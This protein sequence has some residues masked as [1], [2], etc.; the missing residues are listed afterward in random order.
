MPRKAARANQSTPTK[1]TPGT[2]ITIPLNDDHSEKARRAAKRQTLQEAQ[3]NKIIAA[4]TPRKAATTQPEGSPVVVTPGRGGVNI[5]DAQTP[6]KKVPI[7]ANFEEWMKMATDNKINAANSWNFALIDY[8]HD[9]SLLK[10][11]N[12]VNFQKASCTLD[13]CVKIYT[14]RVDSVATETGKLLSG[15]A[16]N[17]GKKKGDQEEGG[18][19]GEDGDD[20]DEEGGKRKARKRATRSE[21]TLAKDISQLQLKKFDLEF[22]VDPLFKKAAADFD[23]GGAKGLLLNVLSIDEH[24][25]I[26]F[27]SSDD[28]KDSTNNAEP[29]DLVNVDGDEEDEPEEA[30]EAE[31]DDGVDHM[32]AEDTNVTSTEDNPTGEKKKKEG[33]S[34][35]PLDLNALASKFFPDLANIE[36]L[37]IC[38]SL[39]NF[40]LGDP[41]ASLD[42]P[43]LKALTEKEEEEQAA[44]GNDFD[45]GFDDDDD[46]GGGFDVAVPGGADATALYGQGGEAWASET[47]GGALVTP[48]KGSGQ[49]QDID[50]DG[51][52]EFNMNDDDY[53][54]K[55]GASR[56]NE[57]ED[58]L[59]YFDEALKKNW[60]GPEHWR[61][62]RIKEGNAREAAVRPR[63]E[64]TPFTIDFVTPDENLDDTDK[65]FATSNAS[66]SL[67]KTQI[68]NKTRNLLP[69]DKHFNSRQLLRL[70]LKPKAMLRSKKMIKGQMQV[71][72]SGG[73]QDEMVMDEQFWAQN[74]IAVTST[75]E[76]QQGDYDA[77]FFHDEPMGGLNDDDE[78]FADAREMF[79]P[80]ADG[81]GAAPA[82]DE[83]G[84]PVIPLL[85]SIKPEV[86]Y[87]A[88]LVTSSRRVRPEYVQYARVA[89]KV[90]V[91]KLKETMWRGMEFESIDLPPQTPGK[92]QLPQPAPEPKTPPP[93]EFPRTFT[94]LMN[95]LKGYYPKQ[96]MNDISTSYC[97]IS[98]LHLANEKGLQIAGDGTLKE[99]YIVR[100]PDAEVGGEY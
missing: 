2:T 1:T 100:D 70:F 74:E 90:D 61:I 8:F 77:N 69:D 94:T 92:A 26:V 62:R 23:E 85:D 96:A 60:A 98:L 87:G 59:A 22:A 55:L 35:V 84:N 48:G 33:A 6:Q 81:A 10:E 52:G 27:D 30:Q 99:L 64:K 17:S 24:G 93:P 32:D 63:K 29:A 54:V 71:R 53:I 56:E 9:M 78:D 41:N 49:I 47:M 5:V 51:D 12:S 82:V 19:E 72:G 34:N 91:R 58:I 89:K 66:V 57:Q 88:Q 31:V 39:K 80:E 44:E 28:V 3:L 65:I 97:F 13:G 36:E 45:G 46:F 37:D 20:D 50:I 21:A 18:G 68:R 76:R 14:S 75:P 73:D 42:I 4:A 83:N 79:S 7:L 67:P 16:D 40:A 38:P 43:F 95:G 25:K 86:G 15:L 11:G